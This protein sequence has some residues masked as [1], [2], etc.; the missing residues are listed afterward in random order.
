M[1]AGIHATT[2]KNLSSGN[3]RGYTVQ[4]SY[5]GRCDGAD[6]GAAPHSPGAKLDLPAIALC[7]IRQ[8]Y[9]IAPDGTSWALRPSIRQEKAIIQPD[10]P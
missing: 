10:G 1:C 9:V 5:N 2:I 3:P 6:P 7:G 4:Y 8:A